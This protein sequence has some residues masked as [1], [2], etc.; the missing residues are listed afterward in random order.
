MHK[1]DGYF[2]GGTLYTK[3]LVVT[4]EYLNFDKTIKNTKFKKKS[5]FIFQKSIKKIKF[6]IFK[7][8]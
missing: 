6:F 3:R 4:G 8:L 2:C 7:N 1:T 5:N